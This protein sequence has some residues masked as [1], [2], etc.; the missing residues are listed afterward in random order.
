[1]P[2]TL[3]KI[4]ISG[5]RGATSK[6]EIPFEPSKSVTMVFG[7][8]GTGKST[9]AD[10]FDFI[11]NGKLGSLENYSLGGNA[12]K[13]IA[14]L[15]TKPSDISVVITCNGKTWSATLDKD[16]PLVKPEIGCPDARILR[17]ANMLEFIN[18]QPK[19]RF[20]ALKRFIA[21]PGIEKSEN[22]LREAIKTTETSFNEYVRGIEQAE[23]GLTKLWEAEGSAGKT[24]IQ[25]AEAETQKD[26]S[27][28][29]TVIK[30]ID[31]ITSAIQGVETSLSSL[32]IASK[33]LIESEKIY[34]EAVSNQ[35]QAEEKQSQKNSKLVALLKDAKMYVTQ[36][37]EGK[38]PLCEQQVDPSNLL[39]RLSERIDEMKELSV[40]VD[41]TGTAIK[42]VELKKSAANQAQKSF[43]QQ[44]KLAAVALKKSTLQE[45]AQINIDW[46][47]FEDI[48]T[49]E[50]PSDVSE[51]QGRRLLQ[52]ATPFKQSF[53]DRKIADQKSI[54]QF[55]AIKGFVETLNQKQEDA[56]ATEILVG[57]LKKAMDIVSTQRKNYVEEILVN[58][59]GE[60]ETQY[61]KLHPGENIGKIRFYLKPNT[62][63]SLEFDAQFQS[64]SDLPPQAYYSESHLDT[65]GICVFLALAK[66]YK[67]DST[68]II[69]DDVITSVDNVH[70][71][72]LMQLLHD[73]SSNFNHVI[74]TTH[75]RPWRDKYRYHQ[76]PAAKVHFVELLNWSLAKGIRHTKT[77]LS[78]DELQEY[79]NAEPLDRQIVASKAGILLESL[80]DYLTILYQCRMPRRRDTNY[81]LSDLISGVGKNLRKSL[82]VVH[83]DPDSKVEDE[84]YLLDI[85]TDLSGMTWLRNQ[86][87]CHWNIVGGSVSDQEVDNF[88]KKTLDLAQLLICKQ[89]GE[90][91]Y[92]ENPAGHW[93]SKGGH[94]RLFPLNNP[95]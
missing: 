34:T 1:M 93:E 44:C 4:I 35:K 87:G 95:D 47:I 54:N 69:L 60:V 66:Y 9:I 7:E 49:Q 30:E 68:I 13:H 57:K 63:G 38:C 24:A 52:M 27:K 5:F 43:C 80:L 51:Q 37:Q 17:R 29:Q 74:I 16:K 19:E 50:D 48:L 56:K 39:N 58:I 23:D 46:T 22:T 71:D 28:L 84:R 73:E 83:V 67:K 62:I 76:G 94:T 33:A 92:R 40:V 79:L 82:K 2:T 77:K 85:I 14:S 86:V 12:R 64:K 32:D 26:T 3:G 90:L 72:R 42:Q 61:S 53:L 78:V 6:A 20:E 89:S 41:A 10:A 81:V 70:L 11:C 88:V 36:K 91:P 59:S 65:L 25:W 45:V 75:Y 31:G 8:N 18:A 55:N 15:G 21:V